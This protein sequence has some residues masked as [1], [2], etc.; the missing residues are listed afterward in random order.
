MNNDTWI[1]KK[2][3]RY[4]YYRFRDSEYYALAVIALTIL[5]SIILVFAIIIPEL[6]QWF[7][8]R[9]E[10]IATR[11]KI[12]T[13]Q[14]NITFIN[15]MDRNTLNSQLQT[16]SDALP[17][18]KNFGFMINALTNAAATSG[19][20]LNDYAFQVGSITAKSG[21]PTAALAN[22]LSTIQI[23]VTV[24][25]DIKSI[26]RFITSLENNLPVSEVTNINGSGQNVSLTVQFYQ[27]P[28]Q[29]I[30]FSPETP[31]A[32]LSADKVGLLQKISKWDNTNTNQTQTSQESSDSA[33]P[34]F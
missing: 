33:V 8:I 30:T 31:L 14:Q 28:F 9:D 27:K 16:V 34:L 29:S 26:K 19:V 17:P 23:T 5:G 11:Q 10:V 15:N 32:P 21:Q 1:G 20:S 13:I 4:W 22:G 25:G 12:A 18:E 3:F 24:N 6:T 7:S 2:G